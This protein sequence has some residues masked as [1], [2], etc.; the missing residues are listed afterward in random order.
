MSYGDHDERLIEDIR[1]PDDGDGFNSRQAHVR[2]QAIGALEERYL[3]QHSF[4]GRAA[5]AADEASVLPISSFRYTRIPPLALLDAPAVA[6]AAPVG[7]MLLGADLYVWRAG[8]RLN[9]QTRSIWGPVRRWALAAFV[10][11]AAL[12][13]HA[14][15]GVRT[16]RLPH[17]S[18]KYSATRGVYIDWLEERR[19]WQ[20]KWAFFPLAVALALFLIVVPL[21]ISTHT[22][23]PKS[24]GSQQPTQSNAQLFNPAS[25]G[26]NNASSSSSTGSQSASLPNVPPSSGDQTQGSGSGTTAPPNNGGGTASVGLGGGNTAGTVTVPISSGSTTI[27]TSSTGST[28]PTTSS[29]G[30][31]GTSTPSSPTSSSSLPVL[32]NTSTV[33]V[34]PLGVNAGG[35]QLVGTS[36]TNVTLN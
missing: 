25:S 30:S 3:R 17:L 23:V 33:S 12:A 5:A 24:P 11:A 20:L 36:G 1:P 8:H 14:W 31:S 27:P 21:E 32:N 6:V 29:S 2:R 34:P 26:S 28:P 4:V 19:L 22:S 18:R 9:M 7:A 35:K 10:G 15:Q 13:A 16:L